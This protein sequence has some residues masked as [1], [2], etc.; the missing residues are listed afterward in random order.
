M[1]ET[2]VYRV[3]DRYGRGPWQ[4]GL[5]MKWI[6]DRPQSEY[7]ALKPIMLEF[8]RLLGQLRDGF[9]FGCGCTSLEK[10]RRW[11][12]PSEW[13]TLMRMGFR[14]YAIV[15]DRI[16]CESETQCVFE[17][18]IQLKKHRNRIQLYPA[19]VMEVS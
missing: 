13:R 5:S 19:C 15:P 7:A 8:P 18:R 17:S 3:Q 16:V 6:E 11:I 10:L 9:H 1:E 14:C 4:P 2:I 12:Q